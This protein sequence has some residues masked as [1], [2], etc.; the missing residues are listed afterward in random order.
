MLPALDELRRDV[1]D[2]S[3]GVILYKYVKS[4]PLFLLLRHQRGGHWGAPK[5]HIEPGETPTDCALRELREETGIQI[6][7]VDPGFFFAIVY[8]VEK[9][10]RA[11]M[12]RAGYYLAEVPIN[13]R[14]TLSNEHTASV[15][16]PA[17]DSVK[18][19]HDNFA[20]AI[21]AADRYVATR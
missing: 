17:V 18:K 8:P 7:A 9:G 16:L 20:D 19:V 2:L 1:D 4:Q 6:N 11:I 13:A 15:W 21:R 12:K 5:G 3:L 10:G 14:E